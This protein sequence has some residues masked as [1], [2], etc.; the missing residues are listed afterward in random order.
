MDIILN[1]FITTAFPD[2]TLYDLLMDLDSLELDYQVDYY[3]F[4]ATAP[5][6]KVASIVDKVLDNMGAGITISNA[7]DN[8][9]A[10]G[11]EITEAMIDAYKDAGIKSI[12]ILVNID[13]KIN[14]S[15]SIDSG[16]M[17][18]LF[19]LVTMITKKDMYVIISLDSTSGWADPIPDNAE[20][21]KKHMCEVWT[22]FAKTFKIVD[23]HVLFELLN[24]PKAAGFSESQPAS[25]IAA[26]IAQTDTYG[27]QTQNSS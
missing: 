2:V 17:E 3:E 18:K 26:A 8:E 22:A 21:G 19:D 11:S 1:D 7:L 6:K 13:S 15:Y 27:T 16:F 25:Q 20:L 23:S 14:A 9:N 10:T 24:K 5:R 12:R 4:G